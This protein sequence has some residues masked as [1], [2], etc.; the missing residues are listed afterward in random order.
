M[1]RNDARQIML[2]QLYI[3]LDHV[4]DFILNKIRK[5]NIRLIAGRKRIARPR[6]QI[7]RFV[8]VELRADAQTEGRKLLRVII[9]I[10]LNLGENLFIHDRPLI[11]LRVR[12]VLRLDQVEKIL[13]KSIRQVAHAFL[14]PAFML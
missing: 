9:H 6:Q 13:R 1:S 3:Q 4:I 11:H 8:Q 7:P 14:Q 2:L 5:N 10:I 12:H